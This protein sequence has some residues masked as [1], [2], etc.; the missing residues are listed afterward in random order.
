MSRY[1]ENYSLQAPNAVSVLLRQLWSPFQVNLKGEVA[2][3]FTSFQNYFHSMAWISLLLQDQILLISVRYS[4][5]YTDNI[6]AFSLKYTLVYDRAVN[7]LPLSQ[8]YRRRISHVKCLCCFMQA[9]SSDLF[10][11]DVDL[12]REVDPHCA[13]ALQRT[14]VLGPYSIVQN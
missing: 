11:F 13:R 12:Q 14:V 2:L 4:P 6:C 10:F 7:L 3:A 9:N 5:K 8:P 1:T